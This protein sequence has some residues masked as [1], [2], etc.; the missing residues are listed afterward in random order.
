MARSL[1]IALGAPSLGLGVFYLRPEIGVEF[2]SRI[3]GDLGHAP[4]IGLGAGFEFRPR[5]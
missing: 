4:I 3:H 5:S 1:R 2:A